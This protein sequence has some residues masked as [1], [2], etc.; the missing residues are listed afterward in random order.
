MVV[1]DNGGEFMNS[2]FIELCEQLNIVV[3]HTAGRS[4]WSNG[5]VEH[6]G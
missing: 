6:H 2:K 1:S 5:L 4:P 3:Q